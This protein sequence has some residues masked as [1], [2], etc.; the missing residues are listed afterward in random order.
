[1]K[2]IMFII[3]VLSSFTGFLNSKVI[4]NSAHSETSVSKFGERRTNSYSQ[5]A[6]AV[7]QEVD[8]EFRLP[9]SIYQN[10]RSEVYVGDP[11][12][13][14]YSANIPAAFYNQHSL[15]QTIYQQAQ[16]NQYGWIN[17]LI[18][19]LV[20]AIRYSPHSIQ[21]WMAQTE[22]SFFEDTEDWVPAENF[23]LVY[24]NAN[25]YPLTGHLES[26]YIPLDTPFPYTAGNLVIM[27]NKV[28]SAWDASPYIRWLY[29]TSPVV[30]NTI[31]ALRQPPEAGFDPELGFPSTSTGEYVINNSTAP[32]MILN[33]ADEQ[34]FRLSL[35]GFKGE[36]FIALYTPFDYALQIRNSGNNATNAYTIKLMSNT[37]ELL[38]IPGLLIQPAETRTIYLPYTFTI[39]GNYEVRAVVDFPS[40]SQNLVSS[41][42][43]IKVY[44]SGYAL[45][46][47]GTFPSNSYANSPIHDAMNKSSVAQVIYQE[48]LLGNFK[49]MLTEMVFFYLRSNGMNPENCYGEMYLSPTMLNQVGIENNWDNRKNFFEPLSQY[50]LSF[51]EI[52]PWHVAAGTHIPVSFVLSEPYFYTGGNLSVMTYV[53]WLE[54]DPISGIND[55]AIWEHSN[56][57]YWSWGFTAHNETE[58]QLSNNWEELFDI[59]EICFWGKTVPNAIFI[60]QTTGFGSISGRVLDDQ[61]NPLRH[62]QIEV[63]NMDQ[64][65]STNASGAFRIDLVDPGLY[66]L[67]VTHGD[68]HPTEVALVEVVA[69][70]VT[71]LENPIILHPLVSDVDLSLPLQYTSLKANYPNPFNPS[72]MISFDLAEAGNIQIEIF[73][74]KGQKVK[75][76]FQSFLNRGSYK[77][78]WNGVDSTGKPVSSGIYFYRL[79]TENYTS[80]KKMLL[81]K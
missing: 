54:D 26:V 70:Q 73:N 37:T 40:G 15:N 80:T 45:T 12:S 7:G 14:S 22:Q 33:F 68:F 41:T 49:G 55:S 6:P 51:S 3:I 50:T 77:I 59:T 34:E 48:E 81:L 42:I 20:D 72:T 19:P 10:T 8:D 39:E 67:L 13:T 21:I 38:T 11:S 18:Y 5:I 30:N 76:V 66:T 24:E 65:V 69:N 27:T 4:L 60:S 56:V 36:N 47:V 61:Q 78:E 29:T 52:L 64:V 57:D 31:H 23:T 46:P 74:L 9:R 28:G 63:Q 16:I 32:N 79:S 25:G 75:T 1:M 43:P 71:N 58:L 2:R 44:P 53:P 35:R 62:V 17:E